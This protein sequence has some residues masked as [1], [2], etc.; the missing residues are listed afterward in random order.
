MKNILVVDGNSVLFRAYYATLYGASSS[1]S[2]R[3]GI[4]TNAVF[5]FVN[6]LNKA[7]DLL[8]PDGVFVAWDAGKQTFRHEMYSEYKGTRKELDDSLKIQFPIVREYL[9]ARG[10]TRYEEVG[11]EAD[12]IIG[13]FVKSHPEYQIHI[14]SSDKDLLQLIGPNSTV[15]LMKKGITQLEKMDE[16]QLLE[17]M[18]LTPSQII[19]MKALMGDTA[20]NIP[21][22]KGIGEKTALKLLHTYGNIEC[23]YESIDE[24]KGKMKEKLEAG[25]DIAFLSKKLATIYTD[26]TLQLNME[27]IWLKEDIDALNAFYLKYEMNSF[28]KEKKA[29]VIPSLKVEV[30]SKVPTTFL[31]DD[32]FIYFDCDNAH[33]SEAKCYGFALSKGSDSVYIKMEDA[34]QDEAFLAFLNSDLRKYSYDVKNGYHALSKL[35]IDF[36]PFHFDVML[37]AFLADSRVNDEANLI[38]HHQLTITMQREDVYSKKNKGKIDTDKQVTHA[39]E[40]AQAYASICEVVMKQ[41]EAQNLMKLFNEIELPLSYVLYE[42]EEEGISVSRDTLQELAA[43]LE[44]QLEALTKQIYEYAGGEFNI[45]SPKQLAVVLYDQLGLKSGKKRS[46]AADVL[47]KL[48]Y[49]HPIIEAILQYRKYAKIHSTYAIALQKHIAEDGRIHTIF[50][51]IQTTTGRISSSEPNLQNISVRDEVGREVRKAFVASE[52]CV[53][54]S[55]D[56]SQIE[57]RMLA[58]MAQEQKMQ[59]AFCQGADIHTRT[60]SQIFDVE[61]AEVNADM[62][63]SAKTV[64]FGIIYGQSDFGLSEQLNIT[65]IEAREFIEKYFACYPR[66]RT[67]MDDNIAYCEEHGYVKTLFERRRY[68]EEIHDK[69]FMIRSFGKRA[70]MNA[71]LQGSAADLIKLAMVNI[72]QKMKELKMKSKMLLQIHD[73]LIF[74]V[75]LEEQEVMMNLIKEGMEKAMQL[76]VPLVADVNSGDSWFSAK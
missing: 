49:S 8:K 5:G 28:L 35:G 21:G 24:I 2:T 27:D 44:V 62:R 54:V 7:I 56:Y 14:L 61:E 23:L 16:V 3:Q 65:V 74:D 9:D 71:P 53:L 33:F 58:H 4:P 36:Q 76:S 18:Q 17:T 52:G 37:G 46:T 6:M 30:T 66:I 41:L 60:A 70:A 55:A 67:F 59:E 57:L 12:D 34:L 26:A 75:V 72:H 43:Q 29:D 51:Q 63:R 10:I 73:E 15:H 31:S 45:Q 11:I 1:M 38:Q 32:T 69:N 68:I 47:E 13:S 64:N 48:K 20:D 42:M 19:D 50:H 22:V 40:K 25:K 39:L